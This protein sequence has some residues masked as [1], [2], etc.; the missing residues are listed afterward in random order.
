MPWS[1]RPL[2]S[3]RPVLIEQQARVS[4]SGGATAW[5]RIGGQA[6][7]TACDAGRGCGAGVFGKLLRRRPVEIEVANLIGATEGQAVR[8]AI[9]ET[10]FLRLVAR[11][12]GWPLLAG[13]AG[14]AAAQWL[15]VAAGAGSAETDLAAAAGG[16]AAVAALLI[17]RDRTTT[18]DIGSGDIRLLEAGGAAGACGGVSGLNSNLENS[19][20]EQ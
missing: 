2:H 1:R 7:C 20:V 6:G 16:L 13:L 18:P 11:L 14:A 17:L 10:L 8:L 4:R 5:V 15:S 3:N 12:Y 9:A 19:E